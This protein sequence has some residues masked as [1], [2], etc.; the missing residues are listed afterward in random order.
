MSHDK[1]QAA[2]RT[3]TTPQVTTP[4][5]TTP[6]VTTPQVVAIGASAG[7]I[8]ALQAFFSAVP[9]DLG[10]AYVVVV[11]LA[12]DRQSELPHILKR[13]TAMP[14]RQVGDHD[15]VKLEPDHVYVIAP[16]RKLE[17]TDSSIGASRFEQPRGRR[18]P[19]DLFFRSL[20]E[21]HGDGYAIILSGS[22]SDGA[23][24]ARAIKEAGGLVLVQDPNEAAHDGMPRSVISTGVADL[25]QPVKVLAERLAA[26]ARDKPDVERLVR[27]AE[28]KEL[29]VDEA[30]ERSLR[31]IFDLLRK[32]TGHDFSKYKRG[33]VLRRLTRR[34]QL[35]HISRLE[36]YCEYLKSNAEEVQALFDDMLISVTTFFRD[37]EAWSA[38]KEQVIGPLIED[39]QPDVPIRAW[40]PG[41]A[42]GEEAY[43]LAILFQEELDQRGIDHAVT[44]FA[45]D[46]DEGALATAREGVYPDTIAADVSEAR[47]K[48]FFRRQDQT[49]RVTRMIRDRVV[50][51]VHS[52][53]RDP[54][55]SRLH[56]ISCRNLLIFLDRDLQE[57]VIGLFQ[58]A[59]R[60]EGYL[61]LG[62]SEM[63]HEDAFRAIDAKHRIFQVQGPAVS[64]HVHLPALLATPRGML[65]QEREPRGL[66]RQASAEIHLEALE[67]VAPPSLIVDR[68]WTILHVSN[69]AARFLQ[70]RGGPIARQVIDAV[71]P[72]LRDE[73]HMVLHRAFEDSLEPQ[74]SA[75]VA[76]RFN[77]V[78][79]RI[80]VLAQRRD[81]PDR[82][83]QLVLLTF[84]ETGPS[85]PEHSSNDA[86][87]GDVIV[88]SLREK[89]RQAELRAEGMRDDY[90]LANE[91]LRAANEELQSL[92][93]EYRSTTEELETSKEELQSINEELQT[94]NNELKNKVEALSDANDDLENLMAATNIPTLF[95]DREL[96]IKRFTPGIAQLF[97]VTSKDHGRALGSFT[98]RLAYDSLHDDV[99]SV[100]GSGK[101]LEREVESDDGRTYIARIS[102]YVTLSEAME[103]IALTFVDV[104]RLKSAQS[105]LQESEEQFRALVDASAQMVWR[106]DAHGLVAA[107]SPSWRAFTGQ[108]K[109]QW[110]SSWFEAVHPD[111]R[112]EV[113]RIWQA[114]VAKG[115]DTA[116]EFRV[117]HA[118]TGAYRWTTLRAAP[119]RRCDGSVRGWVGMHIDVHESRVAEQHL[120]QADRRKDDFLAM[121][122]HELRNPLAAIRSSIAVHRANAS[123]DGTESRAW[124][125][126]DR[127]SRHMARL[128]NDLL[129]IVR[130]DRGKLRLERASVTVKDSIDDVIE[131]ARPGIEAA[132][133]NIRVDLPESPLYVD[134]DAERLLQILDNLLRNAIS[135][136]NRGDVITI[137]ARRNVETAILTVQDTG[138]GMDARQIGTVFERYRQANVD[139]PGSGLGLGLTLIKQLVELHGGTIAARSKGLGEGSEFE[140]TLPIASKQPGALRTAPERPPSRNILVVEDQVDVADMFAAVLTSMGQHVT[141]AYHGE[142]ALEAVCNS[143]PEIAFLDLSMPGMGGNELAHKLREKLGSAA[144][145]L[146]ALS[147]YG[148]ETRT[149]CEAFDCHLLKPID[150]RELIALLRTAGRGAE[151]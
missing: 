62:I 5:V 106:M 134:A 29:S 112:V 140:I 115:E 24:G 90:H 141:V 137:R 130:I 69:S 66:T 43:G 97:N 92:N 108:S 68:N 129:E 42:T 118:P 91:D 113:E 103:G 28:N 99:R 40:V 11:H 36:D 73:V 75:F 6:Q 20:A 109:E 64:S 119:L 81:R 59:C 53:L 131:A 101:S 150:N 72:D 44:I 1:D 95:L 148:I 16:G 116:A 125:I 55:F 57:Q 18:S 82:G 88:R 111:D 10:L 15:T 104:S 50:F 122:G 145:Y 136:S 26:Y 21:N 83:S 13:Q 54:P 39:A 87:H 31:G 120:R 132:G 7:G 102:P 35:S 60:P 84:L 100:L 4:Q 135:Y 126:V 93:E 65:R 27:N 25:V 146:V 47:L 12:P 41:C 49:Y 22:G 96:C 33:T 98:H 124:T 61:F 63:A 117:Y 86:E 34:M 80:A 45:S 107:D 67:A 94:V 32:R 58:Y 149:G 30:E 123:D 46:V 110:T 9:T 128:I 48:R 74:L 56:L 8:E 133:L 2:E 77:G 52:I 79:R 38:L 78:A 70:Q 23:L 151:G 121:L 144:P 51:A 71:H 19:I 147:G 139:R 14:V 114:A 3:D 76:V 37:P 85:G 105:E 17:I 143:A 127:Q 142:Q 138:I 89:L